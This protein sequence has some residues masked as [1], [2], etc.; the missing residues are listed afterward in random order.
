LN[1]EIA[2]RD[3]LWSESIAVGR[4]GFVEKVKLNWASE[5]NIAR[6]PWRMVCILFESR[7]HLTATI[8]IGKMKL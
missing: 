1:A 8:S 6:L 2:G 7:C 4:K 3:D 5:H